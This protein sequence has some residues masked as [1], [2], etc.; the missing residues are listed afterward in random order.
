MMNFKDVLISLS[1]T[2]TSNGK[3]WKEKIV[4]QAKLADSIRKEFKSESSG[5]N[6]TKRNVHSSGMWKKIKQFIIRVV[7]T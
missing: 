7:R 2:H 6:L 4:R 3:S 5:K 1:F